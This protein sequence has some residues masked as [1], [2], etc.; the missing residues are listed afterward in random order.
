LR[1]SRERE[2]DAIRAAAA[3]PARLRALDALEARGVRYVVILGVAA[4]AQRYPSTARD[5]D[6]ETANLELLADALRD[7]GGSLR[8]PKDLSQIPALVATLEERRKRGGP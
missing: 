2:Y 8:V 4:I 5:P 6:R 7:L 1:G 3:G